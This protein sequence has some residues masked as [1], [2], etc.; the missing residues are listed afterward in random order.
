MDTIKTEVIEQEPNWEMVLRFTLENQ[1]QPEFIAAFDD[2]EDLQRH[3][4]SVR[5]M[6][7]KQAK[8]KEAKPQKPNGDTHRINPCESFH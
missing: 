1:H 3:I 7:A 5:R 4:E 6:A 2:E 8:E